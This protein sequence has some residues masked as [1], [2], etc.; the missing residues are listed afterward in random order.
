MEAERLAALEAAAAEEEKEKKCTTLSYLRPLNKSVREKTLM[1]PPPLRLLLRKAKA[2]A[3]TYGSATKR[4]R[5]DGNGRSRRG[6]SAT[7]SRGGFSTS[8]R[9][10]LYGSSSS[11][12][13]NKKNAAA[14]GGHPRSSQSAP[15]HVGRTS[16]RLV[17]G[18]PQSALGRFKTRLGNT[19]EH[20]LEAASRS[21]LRGTVRGRSRSAGRSR[22]VAN[23]ATRNRRGNAT[24]RSVIHHSS[25]SPV[26]N[27]RSAWFRPTMGTIVQAA[28]PP[29]R[30]ALRG[31][32][33]PAG[34]Q[35]D[36]R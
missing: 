26:K 18:A 7:T 25:P 24:K 17:R 8:P 22:A 6:R 4:S 13:R 16:S 35:M 10:G 19:T 32:G 20:R 28:A 15:G 29:S 34:V 36:S 33:G 30:L 31:R 3:G 2:K 27:G 14:R 21:G 11:R 1:E 23:A 9:G 5:D 12:S